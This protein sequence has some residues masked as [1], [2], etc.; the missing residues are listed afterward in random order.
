MAKKKKSPGSDRREQTNH[1]T[2]TCTLIKQCGEA[3][4]NGKTGMEMLHLCVEIPFSSTLACHVVRALRKKNKKNTGLHA[5][6]LL[7]RLCDTW[8]H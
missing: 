5:Q 2:I 3:A 7:P 8:Q 1:F 4:L 6:S